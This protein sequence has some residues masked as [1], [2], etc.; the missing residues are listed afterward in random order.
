MAVIIDGKKIAE[1]MKNSLKEEI[2]KSG[3]K[4]KL[5]IVQV[6]ED[7]VSKKFIE[8]KIKFAEETG[9]KTKIY[10]LPEDISTN[11]LRQKIAEISHIKE[12][13]GV[14]LQLPLPKY[15]NTQYVLNGIIPKKDVDVL[16]SRAFGDFT[17]N[18]SKILPPLVGVIKEIFEKFKIDIIGKNVVVIG[19]GILV[20]KPIANYLMDKGATVSVLSS[21]TLNPSAYILMADIIIS[22]AGK[23]HLIK[24][25]MVKNGVIII[26]AGISSLIGLGRPGSL[27]G[28]VD[29]EVAKKASFF[30]PVSGGVGPITVA[31]VFRNLVEL[32]KR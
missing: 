31:M 32:N 26:D 7:E 16:S 27:V 24:P 28:D 14:I 22:G 11:K 25:D 30:T 17:T 2:L 15:I 13:N 1:E 20:G 12:N 6:G 4:L 5:A 8:R 23:P 21:Q 9:V 3:K 10:N 29:S 18:R 19:K